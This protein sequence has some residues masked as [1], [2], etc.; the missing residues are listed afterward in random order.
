V[1]LHLRRDR[2]NETAKQTRS[3]RRHPGAATGSTRCPAATTACTPETSYEPFFGLNRDLLP[4]VASR[5][6]NVPRLRRFARPVRIIFGAADP[7][8]NAG[9]ARRFH[10]LL[11]TSELFLLPGAR[12]YVQL[13]EPAQVAQLILGASAR[14]SS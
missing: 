7:Y 11:P 10:D 13:D 14:R 6:A 4:T 1:Y 8:L 12:H 5:T 3:R 9:V 2:W